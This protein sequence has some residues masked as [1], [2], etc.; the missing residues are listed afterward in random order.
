MKVFK[1]G[2]ASVRDAE[3][4]RNMA[5]IIDSYKSERLIVV[6]SAMGKITN[7]LEKLI[8]SLSRGEDVAPGLQDLVN[9]HQ[10]I[11]DDL[12]TKLDHPIRQELDQ[13]MSD[14]KDALLEISND[15]AAHY[16]QVVCYGELLSTRI[17]YHYLNQEGITCQLLD[18]RDLII[19][20]NT[21]KEG[22]VLWE[23]TEQ[24]LRHILK[25]ESS[26]MFISQGFI[27]ASFQGATTTLG[28]E[29]SDFSAAIF[30]YCLDAESVTI[31]K[32]VPGILNADPDRW[33]D[34]MRYPSLSYAEAAEMTYYG[35]TVIH[36]KTIRPLALKK[37]PLQVRSFV[38]P[39]AVG[40]IIGGDDQHD[41][42]PAII[43]KDNQ[44]LI[45]FQVRDFTFINESKLSLILH[46]L[47]SQNIRI[48]MMQ[49]SAISFSICI[50]SP[51]D[52]LKSLINDL[53]QDF[54][55][56]YNDHLEL[57][58]V[59]NYRQPIVDSIKKGRQILL[60]Q[61]SRKNY[62]ML[63]TTDFRGVLA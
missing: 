47:E 49:S 42:E 33:P 23:L 17:I 43:H 41:L 29:G 11:V 16:D 27:S 30:A 40:T 24:K 44:C 63:A 1:F 58:T 36:P 7:A 13:L 26:S 55:I 57:I 25:H 31:W 3:A 61:K 6:I 18:A 60:Q 20:D 9:F 8:I 52:K 32:D 54:D 51:D 19:T 46:F 21:F 28:R 2:G 39:S 53:S 12:F 62:Q 35:A 4:V 38:N 10:E 37:I 45:S 34:T 5:A 14:L 56:L 22:K 59:K 50:D 15:S 48:N